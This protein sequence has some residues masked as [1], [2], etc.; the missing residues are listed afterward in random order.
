ML[1]PFVIEQ[2]VDAPASRIWQALTDK[3]QM[4]QW[5]F[6]VDE[7]KPEAGFHFTFTG[8]DEQQTFLHLCTII[9]VVDKQKL[10]HSW[11]YEGQEEQ[12]YVTWELYEEG[13]KTRVKLTHEGLELI[14]HHGPA[15]ATNNFHEGWKYILG[16]ALKNHV[17]NK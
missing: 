12:T 15:F 1:P 9:E 10:R 13:D 2:V 16:T 11:Q 8:G 6:E 17:E 4:K 5:Y 14:A 3:A 7:F